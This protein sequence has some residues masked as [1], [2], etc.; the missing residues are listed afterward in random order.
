MTHDVRVIISLTEIVTLTQ[1]YQDAKRVMHGGT[2]LLMR[3]QIKKNL[4]DRRISP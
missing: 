4:K 1:T 2:L 3:F